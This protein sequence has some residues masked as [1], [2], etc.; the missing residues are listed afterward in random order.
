MEKEKNKSKHI[1]KK[2]RFG[3]DKA[4]IGKIIAVLLSIVAV[5]I[6]LVTIFTQFFP[7]LKYNGTAME[8]T[9]ESGQYVMAMKTDSIEAGDLVAFYYNNSVL[10]RRVIATEGQQVTVD[11][12]G[13][14]SVDGKEQEEPYA[15]SKTLGQSNQDYPCKVPHNSL[16]VM[17]DNR[18]TSMDSRLKEIGAIDKDRLIG[19][20][21]LY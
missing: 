20:L 11:L 17:G 16:F 9:L 12:F 8:P 15:S 1:R 3:R 21:I 10:V 6:L 18:A 4:A 7:I 13:T 14:V 5:A 2:N 19:K